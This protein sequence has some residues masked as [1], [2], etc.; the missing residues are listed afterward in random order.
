MPAGYT[1]AREWWSLSE[2]G[3]SW[4]DMSFENLIRFDLAVEKSGPATAVP[5]EEITYTYTVTNAGPAAVVPVLTD[6]KI[7]TPQMVDDNTDGYNDGDT[8]VDGRI[9]ADETWSYTAAYTVPMDAAGTSIT[10]VATVIEPESQGWEPG[11]F[12][13]GGDIDLDN[14]SDDWTVDVLSPRIA[15]AKETLG[16]DGTWADGVTVIAGTEVTWRYLVTNP[17]EVPLVNVVVTDDNGTPADD[18]DDVPALYDSGDTDGDSQ[19]DTDETWVFTATGTA[20]GGPYSNFGYADGDYL[21]GETPHA[22]TQASDPSSYTGKTQVSVLKTVDGMSFSGPELTFQLRQDASMAS[23]G[24]ILETKYAN[25]DNGG[26]VEFETLLLPGTYQFVE[27]IPEGYV[28]SYVW[29]DYG[30]DWFRP[31]YEPGEGG[32]DPVIWVAVN[33]TVNADGTIDFQNG[34]QVVK[35]G[36]SIDIDNQTGQM[37][38]TIGYWKN[39]S[40]AAA[41]NGGQEPVLDRMLFKATP[42]GPTIQIGTLLLPGGST[43]DN[44]GTS[45]LRATRLLN[46]STVLTNKKKASDPAWNL[47]AQLVAYRLNQPFGAWMNPTADLAA[48]IAQKMLVNVGFNGEKYTAPP[49]ATLAKWT[50][51]MNYLA[52]ILDAYNNGT[53]PLGQALVMPYPNVGY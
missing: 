49:K 32:E 15:I 8:N 42:K 3:S 25:V 7:G 1:P 31:G 27:L 35:P 23:L 50:A 34:K 41:S 33:F 11:E 21:A 28:P 36:D 38:F 30:V 29:G 47:A 39:H 24:T 37:P 43:A 45:A 19:L 14:N 12:Y 17:G 9:Q 52:K 40:S 13:E 2:P 5:G 18:T 22:V 48:S 51:N 53:L 10:N 46:K 44:A 6:D 20:V 4:R 26:L 16:M